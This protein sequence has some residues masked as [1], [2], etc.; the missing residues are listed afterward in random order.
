MKTLRLVL[1]TQFLFLVSAPSADAATDIVI[2]YSEPLQRLAY[3]RAAND[4]G[5]RKPEDAKIVSMRFDAFGRQFDLALAENRA[6]T[7]VVENQAILDSIEVYRGEIEGEDGT[8]IRITIENDTPKGLLWDGLEMYAID[9][10]NGQTAIYRLA[11]LRI[12]GDALSCSIAETPGNAAEFLK[13]LVAEANA[14]KISQK[15]AGATSEMGVA[16]IGDFEFA[17]DMGAS[18]EAE[19]LTRMNNVDGIFSGQ[20]GVQLNVSRIDVFSSSNDPFTDETTA[21]DLLNEL[22]EY[23]LARSSQRANGLSHLFT[24]RD[25]SGST[26]GIAFGGTYGGAICSDRYGAGLTQATHGATFDSLIAAHEFGHNFGAPHDGSSGSACEAESQDL[27]MA[28]NLTGSDTFSGCSIQVMQDVVVRSGCTVPLPVAD[29]DL[30]AA[31]LTTSVLLGNPG[32]IVFDVNNTGT[33]DITNVQAVVAIP[34]TVTLTSAVH[35]GGNC[36]SGAGNATCSLGTVATGSGST[37]TVT[38]ATPSTGT[39]DFVATVTADGDANNGNDQA[40]T[41][42]TIEPAVELVLNA[43]ATVQIDPN[44]STLIS[45]RVENRASL[46]AT[47]VTLTLTPNAGITVDSATW[48]PG[49][50]DILD[51]VVTCQAASLAA[52]S[53]D[54]LQVQL[55]GISEGAQSYTMSISSSETDRDTSNNS[56]SGRVNVGLVTTAVA[57]TEGSSG[58]GGGAFSLTFLLYLA[59]GSLLSMRRRP[60]QVRR[61]I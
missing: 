22:S 40:S 48:S 60:G 37:I 7:S 20:L 29:V 34:S 57:N 45:P 6:L 2:D 12:S 61:S 47:N 53:N 21:N 3:E 42:L 10:V 15:G 49:S 1:L 58:G 44:Q 52:Q 38:V 23:R 18:S 8:W 17:S 31:E 41:L 11:D 39:A 19:I 26:V 59:V 4:S 9:M 16:V 43:A 54:V 56:A 24:G 51:N 30:V 55:T 50:C 32:T 36:V 5:N 13:V 46:D 35:S 28:P 33:E 27:L 14:N 25:L